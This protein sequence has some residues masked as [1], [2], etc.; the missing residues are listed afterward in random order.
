MTHERPRPRQALRT[1]LLALAAL[2]L[3]AAACG[4]GGPQ[5]ETWRFALEEIE[6]SVQHQ[7]ATRF[8][9]RVEELS[10]GEVDV[11][12]YPYGALGSSGQLTEQVQSGGVQ[13]AFASPG[14]LGS[15]VP[16]VQVFSLHF[17]F[18]DDEEANRKALAHDG[19]VRALL[20]EAYR[21]RGLHLLD[22][23]PEGWMVWTANRAL[24]TPADF[25]GLKIRTM[26]SPLLID[27]YEIYGAS[28]T[29]MPYS[30]VYSGLQLDMIDAQVNPVFAIEEM[31]F[32]EV[33]D[34]MTF[35]DHLPF[36]AT[37]VAQP[38]F[39]DGLP[40]AR[41]ELLGRVVGELE[42][43][44]ARVEQ[45][46]NAT[47]LESIREEGGTEIVRLGDA[48]RQVFREASMPVRDTYREMA[49]ERGARVLELLLEEIRKG[50]AAPAAS[51]EGAAEDA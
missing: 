18:S 26:P 14:H 4:G 34:V 46:L 51:G 43:H 22:I 40:E 42:A 50:E 20:A 5:K 24:R 47:R 12:V 1:A 10:E 27:A 32:H 19:P 35:A 8:E 9:E 17:V 49:G 48:E 11:V 15:V 31:S 23:V 13:L 33:Q 28:P 16:E 2:S 39:V 38:E 37:L 29:P 25:E 45:E 36:V 44:A 41:R 3:G 6:G 30:E 7:Y 21:D